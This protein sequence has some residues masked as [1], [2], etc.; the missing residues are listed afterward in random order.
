MNS[1]TSYLAL[2]WRVSWQYAIVG[3]HFVQ[4]YP[5]RSIVF[6]VGLVIQLIVPLSL[7]HTMTALHQVSTYRELVTYTL[8]ALLVTELTFSPLVDMTGGRVDQG[9]ITAFFLRPISALEIFLIQDIVQIGVSFV[10]PIVM[11]V[12]G[13]VVIF[14]RDIIPVTQSV[15]IQGILALILAL[16]LRRAVNVILA[17][18]FMRTGRGWG[19][20]Y[21]I[22]LIIVALS[23]GLFPTILLP[24]WI[25]S[26]ITLLPF[27]VFAN[28]PALIVTH[29]IADPWHLLAIDSGWCLLF[30]GVAYAAWKGVTRSLESYGG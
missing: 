4:L 25:L 20:N 14:H 15:A 7:W 29:L 18:W 24:R 9:T 23:G 3:V 27:S 13:A 1:L 16:L 11:V 21:I 2:R 22:G 8:T 5:T 28:T 6:A 12:G 17:A 26:L 19:V 10:L 30:F